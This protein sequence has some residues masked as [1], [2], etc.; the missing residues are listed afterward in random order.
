MKQLNRAVAIHECVG[1]NMHMLF[2]GLSS[3]VFT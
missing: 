1:S 3:N 2:S